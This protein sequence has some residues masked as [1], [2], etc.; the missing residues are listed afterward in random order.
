M[1]GFAGYGDPPDEPVV[2]EDSDFPLECADGDSEAL[3]DV[4]HVGAAEVLVLL[5]GGVSPVVAV[6]LGV[7]GAS[8][9]P[10][11]DVL[12]AVGDFVA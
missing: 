12:E 1:A 2:L 11:P 6:V 10:E 5:G 3:A 7:V 4:P 8:C 9:A